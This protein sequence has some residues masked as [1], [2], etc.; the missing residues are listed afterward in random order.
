MA[1]LKGRDPLVTD[2]IEA[3]RQ[4]R[5]RE[6]MIKEVIEKFRQRHKSK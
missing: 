6:K 2:F 4:S 5:K 1:R 3:L